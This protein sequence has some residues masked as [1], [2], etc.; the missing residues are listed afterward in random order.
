MA[1][2]DSTLLPI[3]EPSSQRIVFAGCHIY[4]RWLLERLFAARWQFAHV[5]C[6]A[7]EMAETEHI[8]GYEDLGELADHYNIPVYRPAS[9][10]LRTAKDHEFFEREQFDLLVQGGWQRLF[11]EKVL[12]ELRIGAIGVH[13]S[14]DFLPK[15]RGR[16][17]LNWSIIEGRQ[18][19]INH[20]FLIKPGVDDGDIFDYDVFDITP[21]DTIETLFQKNAILT[22]RMLERSIPRLL[23]GTLTAIPQRGTPSYY[24]KRS[25]SD[26]LIDWEELDVWQIHN[27]VRALTRPYPGAFAALNGVMTTI[28]K[29]AVFDTRIT[30][31]NASYGEVVEVF[32]DRLVVNCRGGLLLVED[33]EAR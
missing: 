2:Q 23:D 17:P 16:S 24:P 1:S 25:P 3:R 22:A 8:S 27:W 31:E 5:V 12:Q 7:P 20:L 10:S 28:W 32:D 33:W 11:P 19:F 6:P 26:G 4:G 18:R 15:G 29:A 30:Y 14:S 13:G 21:F 9:Y